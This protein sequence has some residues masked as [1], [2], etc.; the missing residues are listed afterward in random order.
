MAQ[1][2]NFCASSFPRNWRE[3]VEHQVFPR[4]Q[5]VLQ[6]DVDASTHVTQHALE[7]C[8]LFSFV[9]SFS[10]YNVQNRDLA[11]ASISIVPLLWRYL[12]ETNKE[13]PSHS[14][15]F[16]FW[17]TWKSA[18]CVR[19]FPHTHRLRRYVIVQSPHVIISAICPILHASLAC[20]VLHRD[21]I[22]TI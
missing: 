17:Y 6:L 2:S 19:S 1:E 13:V 12:E 9:F 4:N 21:P 10:L 16:L 3:I 22:H 5:N 7:R 14:H 18:R 20:F 11:F 15:Y 8:V